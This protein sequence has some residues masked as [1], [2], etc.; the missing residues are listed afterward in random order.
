VTINAKSGDQVTLSC[1]ASGLGV[2]TFV[3]GWLL[4]GV[5]VEREIKSSFVITASKKSAGNY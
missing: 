4:N 2:D 5:P 1:L 3:Y